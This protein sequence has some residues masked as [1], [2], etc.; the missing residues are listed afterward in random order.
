ME[1]L[2]RGVDA[3]IGDVEPTDWRGYR[4]AVFELGRKL[5]TLDGKLDKLS[6]KAHVAV[7]PP[8]LDVRTVVHY[9]QDPRVN[10]LLLRPL[11]IGDLQLIADKLG[12]ELV[13]E[14][15]GDGATLGRG[16]AATLV[17]AATR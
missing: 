7:S 9:M 15:D 14:A 13:V 5:P 10:H 4:L 3:F 17:V 2:D 8:R 6:L 16:R 12:V 1:F 11:D